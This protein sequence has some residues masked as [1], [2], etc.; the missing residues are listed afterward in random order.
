M[1]SRWPAN[2]AKVM[3]QIPGRGDEKNVEL[4]TGQVTPFYQLFDLQRAQQ[5]VGGLEGV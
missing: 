5:E 2:L 3:N 4:A 1:A